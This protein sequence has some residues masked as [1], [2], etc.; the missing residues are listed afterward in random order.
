M[1][2]TICL[3]AVFIAVQTFAQGTASQGTLQN[4]AVSKPKEPKVLLAA[5]TAPMVWGETPM[6]AISKVSGIKFV[7]STDYNQSTFSFINDDTQR[8]TAFHCT[9]TTH[10]AN[11][12]SEQRDESG[13]MVSYDLDWKAETRVRPWIKPRLDYHLIAPGEKMTITIPHMELPVVLSASIVCDVAV[14]EDGT[15]ESA[16]DAALQAIINR[17]IEIAKQDNRLIQAAMELQARGNSIADLHQYV[18]TNFK[19]GMLEYELTN[20]ENNKSLWG[21]EHTAKTDAE[22]IAHFIT[23]HKMREQAWIQAS[24]VTAVVNQ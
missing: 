20:L 14:Y 18:R 4:I 24:K 1:R 12:R 7:D 19:D 16:N 15:A 5:L 10:L 23:D 21:G 9:L 8:M 17:R 13:E 11:G 3:L 6:T 22:K 2:R